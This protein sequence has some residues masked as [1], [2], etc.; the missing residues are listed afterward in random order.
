[1]RK[2]G[3]WPV[4][5]A[6]GVLLLVGVLFLT[7]LPAFAAGGSSH[8]VVSY[9]F[10]SPLVLR[11]LDGTDTVQVK[12]L[13]R[14]G[15][16]GEPVLPYRT[17]QIVLPPNATVTSV[18]VVPS[19]W[20]TLP[21][22]YRVEPGQTPVHL[23]KQEPP[24]PTPPNAA[25]YGTSDWFPSQ[26]AVKWSVQHW[27]GYAL[28]AVDLA[29]VRY[30]PAAGK[31][32]WAQRLTVRVDLRA[33]SRAEAARALGG[34]GKPGDA[35]FLRARVDNPDAVASSTPPAATGTGLLA[36]APAYD[37]VIITSDAL[38]NA[39]G[40][41]RFQDL[42][43][44]RQSQGLNAT[45]VTTE[46][47]YA[48]YPGTRPDGG[49]DNQ[50]RIR[51]FI[52]DAYSTWGT[53]FVLLGGDSDIAEVGGETEPPIVPARYLNALGDDIASDLYYSCLDGSFDE[54][55]DGVYGQYGDGPGGGEVD[56]LAEVH[57][58]RACVDSD[59]E[60]SNLV[61]KTLSYELSAP[62]RTVYMVGEYLG[63]GGVADYASTSK[64]EI[65]TG[66]SEH[67]YTTVGFEDSPFSPT[68]DVSTLYDAPDYTWLPQELIDVINGDIHIINHLGHANNT[69]SMKLSIGDVEALT[70]T[71][72]FIGYTQGCYSGAFDNRGTG[73]S[74]YC[75][76]DCI[77][78]HLTTSAH[79]AVAFVANDRYGWGQYY[80]TDG[81]SQRFDR[82]FWDALLGEAMLEIGA[83]NSD[84]KW[85]NLGYIESDEYGRYCAYETNLFG[86]P[87]LR[88][89]VGVSSWGIVGADRAV[90]STSD[91]MVVTVMDTDLDLD[92]EA[93]DT[94]TVT[95]ASLTET[96]PETLVLT[97][98]SASSKTF[99]G[100]IALTTGA[101]VPDGQLQV[102][103]DDTITVTYLDADDGA[104][105][106]NVPR[107]VTPRVDGIPPD[108]A[109][110]RLAAPNDGSVLLAWPAASDPTGP[111]YYSV[112]R[113]ET[114]GGQDF[115]APIG[116]TTELTYRDEAVVNGVTYYYV[117]RAQD[118]AGNE[119]TN[120]VQKRAVP[121]PLDTF[122]S[123]DMET[124]PG[125]TAEGLWAYGQ[126]TGGGTWSFDPTAGYTGLN[127][128]GYNLY[129]SYPDNMAVPE[130]L[131]AGPLD[132]S[133]LAT[134][135]LNF[136]RWLGVESNTW[137]HAAIQVSR[138]G[139][140]WQTVWENPEQTIADYEWT[141][142]SYDLSPQAAGEPTVYIRWQMGPTDPIVNYAGWNI[143][144]V[145]ILGKENITSEGAVTLDRT[146]YQPAATATITVRDLDLNQ[147]PALPETASVL[148]ASTTEPAGESVVCTEVTPDIGKFVG[149]I[150]LTTGEPAADGQLQV[151]D[152]DTITVTYVDADDGAGG[153]NLPRTAT[154]LVD[155]QAPVF[156]GISSIDVGNGYLDLH[157]APA[158]DD[159]PPVAYRIY[160][161][162]A[163][164]EQDFNSPLAATGGTT[165]RD[166][167]VVHGQSY[168]YVVRAMDAAGNED[169]NTVEASATA[170]F[171]H[172]LYVYG[173][174]GRGYVEID[175][176][177]YAIPASLQVPHGSAITVNAVPYPGYRFAYWSGDIFT[178]DNPVTVVVD[179]DLSICPRFDVI[180]FTLALDRVGNGAAM[181]NGMTV[182]LPNSVEI[183]PWSWVT[184][185][186]LPENDD[187]IDSHWVFDRWS[188]DVNSRDNPIWF[189]MDGNKSL[190]AHFLEHLF[191]LSVSAEPPVVES[192]AR[193]QLAV[194]YSDNLGHS[195]QMYEWTAA[196]DMGNALLGSL[197][198]GSPRDVALQGDYAYVA[199]GGGLA[200][201][202]ISSPAAPQLAGM[203][204]LR[205]QVQGVA[206]LGDYAYL[207]SDLGLT[208][209]DVSDPSA[210]AALG[211]VFHADAGR[212]LA[213][214]WPYV[215]LGG[216]RW[217]MAPELTIVDVTDPNA[218]QVVG[219][220]NTISKL[221]DLAVSGTRLY[222]VGCAGSRL[223]VYDI[224]SPTAPAF[225]ASCDLPMSASL[226]VA[227][228]GD[229]A[230]LSAG[231]GLGV[232]D[233][234]DPAAPFYVGGCFT[235]LSALGLAVSGNH[236]FASDQRGL[237]VFDVS[238][239]AAPAEV[240]V[241]DAA[242]AGEGV[243]IAGSLAHVSTDAGISV[244]DV[245]SPAAPVPVGGA[246][247]FGNCLAA[248]TAGRYAYVAMLD[249]VQIIDMQAPGGPQPVGKYGT[250]WPPDSLAVSEPYLYVASPT[251]DSHIGIEVVDV[252]DPA[253][254]APVG[255][256]EAPGPSGP[257][258]LA[259][260][261][262]HVYLGTQ[263]DGIYVLDMTDPA[264]PTEVG[265]LWM[266][267]GCQG[268][269]A[270]SG[271]VLYVRAAAPWTTMIDVSDPT[272][273]WIIGE[274]VWAS[275]CCSATIAASE[276]RVYV[277]D[278]QML[279]VV[280]M[281]SPSEVSTIAQVNLPGDI[282]HVSAAGRRAYV[283]VGTEKAS[284]LYLVDAT[285]PAH[286]A[287]GAAY[288]SPG[289][290]AWWVAPVAASAQHVTYGVNGWGLS[291]FDQGAVNSAAG[292]EFLPS[293]QAVEPMYQAFWNYAPQDVEV[294]LKA[295]AG[296]DGLPSVGRTASTRVLVRPMVFFDFTPA[297]A[298]PGQV[299]RIPV[300]LD[301]RSRE[302]DRFAFSVALTP[303]EGAQPFAGPLGFEA[304]PSLPAPGL[305][306]PV[307]SS[308]AV[309]WLD[310]VGEPRTGLL[311]L[312]DVLVPISLNAAPGES[313][314][315]AF[316]S[317]GASLGADEVTSHLGD[318]FT[319]R[320]LVKFLVGDSYPLLADL[321]GDGDCDDFSEFGDNDLSWGD[322]IAVFDSW[323]LPGF[324]PVTPGSIRLSA[325]DAYPRDTDTTIG[326]DWRLTWGDVITTFDR[327]ANPGLPRPW[328]TLGLTAPAAMAA[329]APAAAGPTIS[330]GSITG[331]AGTTVKVPV[332]IAL[333]SAS[334]DRAGFAV[335]I[336]A[337][338][339]APP[340]AITGFQAGRGL[341]RPTVRTANG[342]IAIGG[343][344]RAKKALNGQV[345]LGEVLVA[346]PKGAASGSVW[347]LHLESAGASLA[348]A[349]L[350]ATAGSDGAVR[351]K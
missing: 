300:M 286:P 324:Y 346:I 191:Q 216:C 202:D 37:Y 218:P 10:T 172:T 245:S 135:V 146:A 253:H 158:T 195:L 25:V 56:L 142:V 42:V 272:N 98:T 5:P 252:S 140:D 63:F 228:N 66:T 58:G 209:V 3:S 19:A 78:E 103:D 229:H 251:A 54:N 88:I 40:P 298:A 208:I 175:G 52:I 128:Y 314:E 280:S 239:P 267:L 57:V 238:D 343:L 287:V 259:A 113:A 32:Q 303:Q 318:P 77:T 256:W 59:L 194:Q 111:I 199:A 201:Y 207:S 247:A 338:G 270:V 35:A 166:G 90:Y 244:V 188:G 16:P 258:Y 220:F 29:P 317:G 328:R 7:C 316:I 129:G 44:Q 71:S 192:G 292:G 165:Y 125:W 73:S 186:A 36:P 18:S 80:S 180:P 223:W 159:S 119:E 104:G 210:P 174:S 308:I 85:D 266:Y 50:T 67:G 243:A 160:R 282:S 51:N 177:P 273:P 2:S 21:G 233:V 277:G 335:T 333:G 242:R 82:E 319:L 112:Y 9:E 224:A 293:P 269:M 271:T 274:L 8:V 13:P 285:D 339:G 289:N 14:L 131:T 304:D 185:E 263:C 108:F 310:S 162:L 326:G 200:V 176:I 184:L 122:Y 198:G 234:S 91:T 265:H 348:E 81:P 342:A 212:A 43:A 106:V 130:Y 136:Q 301:L 288:Q 87:A 167:A 281:Y 249:G 28:L 150:T 147:N 153:T 151:A 231:N 351:V 315:V 262:S 254:P 76:T 350:A 187:W 27:R 294:I 64:D 336:T 226:A 190:T 110:L 236:L 86:D 334:V 69:Y 145:Q 89:K 169:P 26:P 222:G 132:C 155:G 154:A 340:A 240:A 296:C 6:G 299:A 114:P 53:R 215:Y 126:P 327:W 278:Q 196:T 306:N 295:R 93:P 33:S 41:Y 75:S 101:P 92:P 214:S 20:R 257:A 291:F 163:S 178:S 204:D 197:A 268:E 183:Y 117:V 31:L 100:S 123:W 302:A 179:R 261:G 305:V 173:C 1:V 170:Q 225:L 331:K 213:V 12:G 347:R 30:L 148:V 107:T 95:V 275:G 349:E 22:H 102:A 47:I 221:T 164:G 149:Q 61:A 34:G 309:G 260:S 332:T 74:C 109:G 116:S 138:D 127:V 205:G 144:D 241:C 60:L 121:G 72:Y 237:V 120:T 307:D 235:E 161:A 68:H 341:L 206:V 168:Y 137:D 171:L 217:Q 276:D 15:K 17:G 118:G 279:W 227:V 139:L 97:E 65:R 264:Y 283:A 312:G 157:W 70:N 152:G 219:T 248:E 182:Y 321:D 329:A 133:D 96:T 311:H 337:E 246:A 49:I 62:P 344:S 189:T 4:G 11:H 156:A 181:V 124:D 38:A 105:G 322:S 232:V 39:S 46:W 23:D 99:V 250:Q 345:T 230:Y 115:G 79:G 84:S 83:A 320:V 255:S 297:D 45:I 284:T 323:S 290:G 203:C 141:L 211:S 94:A 55:A 313:Y 325:M 143:D 193:T 330:I 134:V 48:T 24:P